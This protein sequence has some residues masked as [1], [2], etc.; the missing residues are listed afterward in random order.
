MMTQ[1][2]IMLRIAQVELEEQR[3]KEKFEQLADDIA[4][5]QKTLHRTL[6]PSLK[7][8]PPGELSAI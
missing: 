5:Q 2:Q 8:R 4:M 1:Q 6:K 7:N 3:T